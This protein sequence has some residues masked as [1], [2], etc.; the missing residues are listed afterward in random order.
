MTASSTDA[1]TAYFMGRQRP[2]ISGQRPHATRNF[3]SP[4]AALSQARPLL[5]ATVA[6]KPPWSSVSNDLGPG[7][8]WQPV[9]GFG[10][11]WQTTRPRSGAPLRSVAV[12]LGDG[13]LAIFSPLRGLGDE[14]HAELAAVGRPAFLIAPNHYHNLGLTEHVARYPD[15]TVVAAAA[16]IPR[17]ARRCKLRVESET[18]LPPALAVL[19]PPATR[20]GELWLQLQTPAHR[21]WIVG[22]G[23]FNLAR[24]P[25]SPI[26]LLLRALGIAPGLRIGSS[27][28]WLIRDRARYRQWLLETLASQPP[29]VLVPCHG[30]ILDDQALPARLRRLAETRL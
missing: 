21:A 16:A 24:V 6:M 9:A 18:A 13:R 11:L 4:D 28:R 25:R 1:P 19:V 23:F 30:E 8:N 17:L 10:T 14:T 3:P 15:A 29:T 26:G 22:D 20:N 12:A 2:I 7:K 5:G 27:F